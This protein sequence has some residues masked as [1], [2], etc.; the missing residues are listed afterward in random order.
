MSR[1]TSAGF[2]DLL[3][4]AK[5]TNRLLAAQLRDRMTQKE[6]VELLMTTGASD[7]EI[8]DVLDT[9]PATVAVTKQRL[10][11][12]AKGSSKR[13]STTRSS[14]DEGSTD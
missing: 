4:Q 5:V 14:S 2:D 8:A 6:L 12:A 7:R 3:T 10:R 13:K 11:A 9:T 1:Q